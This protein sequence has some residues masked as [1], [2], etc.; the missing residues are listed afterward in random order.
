VDVM[1]CQH[2]LGSNAKGDSWLELASM[3]VL[4]VTA[5][6]SARFLF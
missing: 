4:L 5:D 2:H 1:A 6:A 3:P